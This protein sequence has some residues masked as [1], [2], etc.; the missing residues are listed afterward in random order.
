M[1]VSSKTLHKE[2]GTISQS[3]PDNISET[4]TPAKDTLDDAYTQLLPSTGSQEKVKVTTNFS[5]K[6]YIMYWW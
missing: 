4:P 6:M 3:Q 5:S 2:S 1:R